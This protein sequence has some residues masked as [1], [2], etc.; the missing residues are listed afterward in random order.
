MNMQDKAYYLHSYLPK[1]RKNAVIIENLKRSTGFLRR[2]ITDCMKYLR[3]EGIPVCSCNSEP[4]GYFIAANVEEVLDYITRLTVIA[5]G[6]TQ[7]IADMNTILL[8][9]V[10]DEDVFE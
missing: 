3:K 9:M 5:K 10:G 8:D 4:G 2:A 7:N 1:G 6:I